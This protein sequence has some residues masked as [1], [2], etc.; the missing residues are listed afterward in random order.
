[1]RGG[2]KEEKRERI[3]PGREKRARQLH[4]IGIRAI[5]FPP[6]PQVSPRRD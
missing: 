3:D 4:W 1:M 6:L 5:C 2:K